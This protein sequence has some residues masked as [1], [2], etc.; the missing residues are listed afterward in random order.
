MIEDCSAEL[1]ADEI[2]SSGMIQHCGFISVFN[3]VSPN[4]SY[5]FRLVFLYSGDLRLSGLVLVCF[6]C[7]C[8]YFMS[9]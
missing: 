1:L 2:A 8:E 6:F 5:S 9:I 3:E 7:S 4:C